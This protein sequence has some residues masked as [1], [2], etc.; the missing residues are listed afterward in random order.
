MLEKWSRDFI[1]SVVA[2]RLQSSFQIDAF[3]SQA[4]RSEHQD[5]SCVLI[6]AAMKNEE[7]FRKMYEST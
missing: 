3:I 7:L 4:Q 1:N 5:S 2:D 6:K